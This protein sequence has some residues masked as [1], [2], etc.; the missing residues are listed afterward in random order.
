MA[1]SSAADSQWK[2]GLV[3]VGAMVIVGAAIGGPLWA[4]D[5][6]GGELT[7]VAGAI[8]GAGLGFVIASYLLYGR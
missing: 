8:V 2:T 4:A 6:P 3:I 7:A 5:V 1:T